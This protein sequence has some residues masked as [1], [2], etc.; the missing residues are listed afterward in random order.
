MNLDRLN[1]M[2]VHFS[3]LRQCL[4]FLGAVCAIAF[5][6]TGC[7]RREQVDCCNDSRAFPR[8]STNAPFVPKRQ[9]CATQMVHLSH[10]TAYF[11]VPPDPRRAADTSIVKMDTYGKFSDINIGSRA[12]GVTRDVRDNVYFRTR[13]SIVKISPDGT[14]NTVADLSIQDSADRHNLD[15]NDK[16]GDAQLHSTSS[17]EVAADSAGNVYLLEARMPNVSIRQI[18][19][20]GSATT[21]FKGAV[22]RTPN[23]AVD[24]AFA[25]DSRGNMYLGAMGAIVKIDV[26]GTSI[27]FVG[28]E[29][30]IRHERDGMGREARFGANVASIAV[31]ASDNLY[32]K[33]GSLRKVSPDG[34][35]T[36][37][38]KN[39]PGKHPDLI[40]GDVM[41]SSIS[42]H[43]SIDVDASGNVYFS[44]CENNAY[45]K[46]TADGKVIT[47][48]RGNIES[49]A[50]YL[51][52]ER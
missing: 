14:I 39:E 22:A 11:I 46:I 52:G 38:Y 33:A 16:G 40:D 36:T 6:D 5:L 31:D 51:R 2:T 7:K 21:I 15:T 42:I 30:D 17:T 8:V 35:V 37:L 43:S 32:V 26:H 23:N 19:S 12:L 4:F 29:N 13:T 45:R 34:N 9:L 49:D 48:I 10:G 47:I 41:K 44:D 1:R 28:D 50:R 25:F 3:P 18:N 20:D 27:I 24:I